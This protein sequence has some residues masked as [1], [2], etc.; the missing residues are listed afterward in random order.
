M[1]PETELGP[2]DY[3]LVE[4]PGGAPTFPRALAAE[5]AS[6]VQN[7]FVRVLDLLVLVKDR[8]GFVRAFEM[9]DLEEVVE[10]EGVAGRL[11]DVLAEQDASHLAAAMRPG[12]TAAVV[13]WEHL[14]VAP[15]GAA[16]RRAGGQVVASGRIPP[17]AIGEALAG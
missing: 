9:D 1:T 4:F 11:A 6:L 3:L 2:V 12:T 17:D 8:D 15:F 10:L 14:W 7:G 13:V 5:L 16:A